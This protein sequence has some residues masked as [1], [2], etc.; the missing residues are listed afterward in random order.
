M[1]GTRGEFKCFRERFNG[2]EDLDMYDVYRDSER[3][4]ALARFPVER[5]IEWKRTMGGGA[6]VTSAGS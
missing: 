1:H 4:L 3:L 2:A 5:F 6:P